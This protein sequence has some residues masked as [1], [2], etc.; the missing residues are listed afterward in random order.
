LGR[1]CRGGS[2]VPAHPPAIRTFPFTA[3]F[4]PGWRIHGLHSWKPCA[5][6]EFL[7]QLRHGLG[8]VRRIRT[9]GKHQRRHG[10]RTSAS[11]T[12]TALPIYSLLTC[13]IRIV[14]ATLK[15]AGIICQ[16][17]TRFVP[18]EINYPTPPPSKS[19][20]PLTIKG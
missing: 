18:A 4:L 11:A 8:G 16:E 10:W 17:C 1:C 6:P 9:R 19:T 13:T 20:L 12:S 5:S 15:F 7:G 2:G 14:I 3:T